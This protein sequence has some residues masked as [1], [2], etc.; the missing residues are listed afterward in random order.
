[1]L[2]SLLI[3]N[4]YSYFIFQGKTDI[5]DSERTKLFIALSAAGLAGSLSLL[6]LRKPRIT[7][8][9]DLLSLNTRLVVI[10]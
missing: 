5:T 10:A 1:M 7:D 6:L 8:S 3:G 9:E 4:L 2:L